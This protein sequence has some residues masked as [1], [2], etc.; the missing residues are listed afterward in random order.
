MPTSSPAAV[1][2]QQGRGA[3]EPEWLSEDLGTGLVT[4]CGA[5]LSGQASGLGFPV[6]AHKDNDD[7]V[8]VPGSMG[9]GSIA[10]QGAVGVGVGQPP[11]RP[12][13][14]LPC[15]PPGQ[16]G[17]YAPCLQG[18]VRARGFL[19][20]I[21]G[22]AGLFPSTHVHA[23]THSKHTCSPTWGSEVPPG[24]PG[25]SQPSP[26]KPQKGVSVSQ[27]TRNAQAPVSHLSALG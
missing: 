27:Q 12:H 5:G 26:K 19:L 3:P 9:R 15:Q 17:Q 4:G 11:K 1:G 10:Q 23:G 18:G 24:S 20:N 14:F 6:C 21:Q 2:T 7:D 25:E 8:L 13:P 22:R 16:C